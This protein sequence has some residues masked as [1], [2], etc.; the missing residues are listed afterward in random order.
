[1][2]PIGRKGLSP[3]PPALEH[4]SLM[5]NIPRSL[6]NPEDEVWGGPGPKVDVSTGTVSKSKDSRRV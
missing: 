3:S 6:G 2:W 4:V 1:V 5:T